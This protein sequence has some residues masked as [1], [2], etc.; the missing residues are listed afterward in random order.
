[1][2]VRRM[3][4]GRAFAESQVNADASQPVFEQ[5][6]ASAHHD[7][8]TGVDVRV[9][10]VGEGPPVVFLN[11]LLGQNHHWFR[12]LPPLVDVAECFFVQPPLLE[13]RGPGC[14]VDGVTNLTLSLLD[15]LVDEP[16]VL[17]GN[18]LGGHVALRIALAR[19]EL[20]RGLVL[21]G[22]SGLFEKS[23]EK[24]VQHSPS[25][26]WIRRKIQGLFHDPEKMLP[27]MVEDAH[28]ALSRRSAARAMVKLGRSAKRDHLGERLP[29]IDCPT[30]ICWGRQD[31]VTPPEVAEQFADLLPGSRLRW[32]EACG[33]APQIEQ[34]EALGREIAAFVASLEAGTFVADRDRTGDD[35]EPSADRGGR[36]GRGGRGGRQGV[37]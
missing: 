37:A 7:R 35:E 14:S 19:P 6:T 9:D 15:S 30:L 4:S 1:V 20:A 26:E 34:G 33:H 11:G 25:A 10:R 17:V 28:H 18:S 5:G 8:I 23:F 36:E 29:N 16:A 3:P 27:G 24:D 21:V 13:M 12:T 31:I 32:L 22:S 2:F